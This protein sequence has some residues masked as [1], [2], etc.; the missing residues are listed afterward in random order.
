MYLSLDAKGGL[1]H[2]FNRS[3]YSGYRWFKFQPT[4]DMQRDGINH[5][6]PAGVG[7]NRRKGGFAL[8]VIA[9]AGTNGVARAGQS[10]HGFDGVAPEAAAH[11]S[12]GH[13]SGV[14]QLADL[15]DRIVT[16]TNPLKHRLEAAFLAGLNPHTFK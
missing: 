4:N 15:L 1:V 6:A 5:T 3:A 16:I 12:D 9:V 8:R 2:D 11:E 13:G 14:K 7:V 10:N